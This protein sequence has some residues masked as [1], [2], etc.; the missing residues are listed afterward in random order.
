MSLYLAKTSS[1]QWALVMASGYIDSG[2][3]V[4]QLDNVY[5]YKP[6]AFFL[7]PLSSFYG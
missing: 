6:I 3:F 4:K 1:N 2:S 5:E 7:I